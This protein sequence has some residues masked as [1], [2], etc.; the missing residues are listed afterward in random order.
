MRLAAGVVCLLSTVWAAAEGDQQLESVL[1]PLAEQSLILDVARAGERLVAVGERGHVLLSDDA[2]ARWRQV[3]APTRS[4]LTAVYFPDGRTG[5]A[6]GHDAVILRSRDAGET[7][8]LVYSD[9]E[10]EA[11][12]LD[13]YFFDTQRGMAVGAYAYFVKTADG[14]DSWEPF[15]I[16]EDDDFHLN[17]IASAPNGDLFIAAE[18]GFVYRSTDAAA[19]WESLESPYEGSFF[20]VLNDTDDEL[21]VFGLRGHLYRSGDAGED[22]E[23]VELVTRAMLTDATRMSDGRAVIVGLEGMVLVEREDGYRE[24]QL[25]SRVGLTAVVAVDEQTLVLASDAGLARVR[26]DELR[27]KDN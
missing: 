12:L 8:Q 1:A 14:G 2:G 25:P 23:D 27:A 26:L 4:T 20:G 10:E 3:Q 13:V 16:N 19:S 21:L 9:A 6:V 7:W 24:F 11:P 5:F 17:K 15:A 22:F 18:A